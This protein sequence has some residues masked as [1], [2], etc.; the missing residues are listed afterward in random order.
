MESMDIRE[1]HL[2]AFM[3]V[4]GAEF[5][6]FENRK[7][8]FKTDKPENEWR[9]LHSNSCCRRVDIELIELRKFIK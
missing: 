9:V 3:K 7:F 5:V 4:N 6:K 1:L 8:T 2:A